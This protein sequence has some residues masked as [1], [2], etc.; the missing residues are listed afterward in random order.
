MQYTTDRKWIGGSK[1]ETVASDAKSGSPISAVAYA[2]NATQYVSPCALSIYCANHFQ[3][4]I[5]YIDKNHTVKQLTKTNTTD[6]WQPGPLTDLKLKAFNNPTVGLQACWKGNY[7]GDSDFSKFPTASGEINKQPFEERLGMNIWFAIDDSTFQQYAWYNGQDAW[8][9]I[10]R[11]QGFN[12]HAGVGCYSWGEGTTTYAMLANKQNDI[13]FWWKDTNT[14]TTSQ[15]RHPINSWQNS[16]AG[17]IR[18]VY[19]TT[20]LG[21]TTYFYAQMA[22]KSIKGYNVTY[23][24][25]N[26][27]FVEDNTFTITD[28]AGPV[29]G[30]G[31]THLT[32]TAFAERDANLKT[33]WDSLYVFYQTAGD[34]ITAFTR[35]LAGGEWTKGTL[36]IPN[37]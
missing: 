19:P 30:L 4:H 24:A 16:T 11:W 26:T 7:Y 18:G 28:P 27:T 37:E 6:I 5:F 33:I 1:S 21:Y 14:S 32:V 25:E 22:D 29:P 35:P 15:E 10:Q 31:G 36:T 17:A 23:Q 13:E 9:P 8:V 12:G 34:D 2:I 20:S 3:F